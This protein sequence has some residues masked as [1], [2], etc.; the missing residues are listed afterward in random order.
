MTEPAALGRSNAHP[1]RWLRRHR[2]LWIAPEHHAAVGAEISGTS[3]RSTVVNSLAAGWPVVVRQQAP[4]HERDR[5]NH[6][7][8]VGMPLPPTQR[9]QRVALS[10]APEWIADTA[11]P[12]LLRAVLVGLPQSRR[13][14]LLRLVQRADTIDLELRVYGSVAWEALTGRSYLTPT[15]DID[16]LWQPSTPEQ[17]AAAIAMLAAWEAE[18]GVRVDGEIVFGDDDSVA[19]REW[20]GDGPLREKPSTRVLVKAVF[21]PRLEAR[22]KLLA[23]LARPEVEALAGA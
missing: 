4:E 11:P 17:L 23:S 5:P 1:P 9:K 15:S 3:L 16:L 21:G 7:V 2:L 20:M 10:V 8:A 14:G 12:P 22:G 18:S 6:R 19:W 13:P